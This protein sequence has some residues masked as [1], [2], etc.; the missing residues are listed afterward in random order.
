MRCRLSRNRRFGR[1]YCSAEHCQGLERGGVEW[2]FAKQM[3][4]S[5]CNPERCPLCGEPNNCQLCGTG[6]YKG[7]CWC[8][9]AKIPDELLARVPPGLRN[10]ACICKDCVAAFWRERAERES[11]I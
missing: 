11:S 1:C 8:T 6:P 3:A 7:P 5:P 9:Q 10:R 4:A 2:S